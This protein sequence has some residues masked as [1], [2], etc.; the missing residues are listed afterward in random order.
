MAVTG[1]K[2]FGILF[3]AAV[4]ICGSYSVYRLQ[5]AK[6][7]KAIL[8]ERKA[9]WQVLKQELAYEVKRFKGQAGIMI[10]DLRFD[11]EIS[12]DKDRLFPSASLVKLPIM[13]ACFLASEEG[14]ID[15]GRRVVLKSSD[16]FPGSGTLKGMRPGAAFTVEELIGFMIYDSDNTATNMLTNMLG[17][18]Y[19]NRVFDS[20]GLRNTNLSRRVADFRSRNRGIE[21]YTT[22]GDM[23]WLLEQI[24][25]GRLINREVSKKCLE[26]LKLQHYNDRIPKYLPADVTVAHKTGLE[27][28]VCHDAGIIFGRNGDILICVLTRHKNSNAAASK[29]FIARVAL[30][31]YNYSE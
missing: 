25:L 9:A 13:A 16:K 27:R 8:E 21:N 24:Y 28:G 7:Q 15:L 30:D 11:W 26:V 5:E 22:V 19:L 14:R 17:K 1:R 6:R 4:L 3:I 10:K 29:N 12:Y 20:L 31:T 18:D 23:A 2:K